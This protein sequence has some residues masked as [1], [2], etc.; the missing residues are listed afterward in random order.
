MYKYL[1]PQSGRLACISFHSLEDKIIK[2]LFNDIEINSLLDER[3]Q[4][5]TNTSKSLKNKLKRIK[6]K[7]N[8]QLTED[9]L[10]QTIKKN[11]TP[12]N[13]KVILPSETEIEINPRS[14]SAKLRIAFKN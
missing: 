2:G 10:K 9:T 1:K 8:S 5:E 11:W 4:D 13:K 3:E 12:I 6:F 7:M 14:R